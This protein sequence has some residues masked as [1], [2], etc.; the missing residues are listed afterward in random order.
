MNRS[1]K[2]RQMLVHAIIEYIEKNLHEKLTIHVISQYSGYTKWYLQKLFSFETKI[3]LASYIR[4]RKLSNAA[5]EL[6]ITNNR[7]IDIALKYG[8]E[9]QQSFSR[10]FKENFRLSPFQYRHSSYFELYNYTVPYADIS[11]NYL[12]TAKLVYFRGVKQLSGRM[13]KFNI[14]PSLIAMNQLE[15]RL[16]EVERSNDFDGMVIVYE[17]Q[18]GFNEKILANVFYFSSHEEGSIDINLDYDMYIEVKLDYQSK[19]NNLYTVIDAVKRYSI[20]SNVKL[21]ANS[22]MIKCYNRQDRIVKYYLPVQEV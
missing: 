10:T 15:L 22:A 17:K 14:E 1:K 9:S 4:K 3:P 21:I 19:N 13:D 5:L 12:V 2:N 11:E 6:K 16:N 18:K 20:H 8:F 7:I